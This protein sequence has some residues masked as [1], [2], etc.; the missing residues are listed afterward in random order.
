[1]GRI[2]LEEMEFYAY[3]GC[4]DEEQ[5]IGNQFIVN[6]EFEAD[7]K[8]GE[9][10]DNLDKSVNYQEVYNI[11]DAQMQQ[12]SRL[13]EH[14]AG[15]ILDG[16]LTQFPYITFARIK[17]SK[18]NPPIGGKVKAVSVVLERGRI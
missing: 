17:L 3:H 2:I 7:T 16:V 1:M 14:V 13:L 11:V 6:L 8:H 9:V 12:K 18:M 5:V 4:F 10:N 15:R